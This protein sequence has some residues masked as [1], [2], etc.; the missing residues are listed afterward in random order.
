MSIGSPV[1]KSTRPA[2]IRA[3]GTIDDSQVPALMPTCDPNNCDKIVGFLDGAMF[4]SRST[5]PAPTP[6]RVPVYDRKWNV[7]GWMTAKGW[8]PKT[9]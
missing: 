6:D 7:I 3:D 1:D 2:F 9:S 5:P 8:E 4:K